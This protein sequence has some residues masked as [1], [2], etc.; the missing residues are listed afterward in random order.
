MGDI[1]HDTRREPGEQLPPFWIRAR[2]S[3]GRP[4]DPRVVAVCE[5]AWSWAYRRV[6]LELHDAASA[7]QLM[8]EVAL[9]VSGRLQDAPGVGENLAG[10]FSTAFRHRVRQQFVR[11]NR[12]AYEG[13]LSQLEQNHHLTAPNWEAAMERKLCLKVLIDQ[14]PQPSRH[15]LH[16]RILGFSWNEIG[17]VL[18]LSGKQARSRFYYE[19]DK[20]H[21]KLLGSRAMGAGHGEESD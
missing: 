15:M 21:A 17:R 10:Y 4:V 12:V 6:E 16:Y 5:R 19:L 9:E 8:E 3:Q 11:E 13:L 2:D 14:L 1:Q 7:A 20:A 18:R